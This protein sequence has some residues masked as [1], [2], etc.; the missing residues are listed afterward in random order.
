MNHRQLSAGC[1]TDRPN[2]ADFCQLSRIIHSDPLYNSHL[3][4]KQILNRLRI[5]K[6]SS[7]ADDLNV[8]GVQIKVS[9]R[10]IAGILETDRGA[11]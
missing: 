7:V 11:D 10:D 3:L 4:R 2:S 5:Y 8:T 6:N 9:V 1:D